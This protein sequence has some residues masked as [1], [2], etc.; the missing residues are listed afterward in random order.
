MKASLSMPKGLSE[1][2]ENLAAMGADVDNAAA[3]ALQAGA[4]T[5]LDEMLPNIHVGETGD[6][7]ATFRVGK[8]KREGNVT[9]IL[10]GQPIDKNLTPKRQAIVANVFEYGSSKM[11]A[12]PIVRP[13]MTG[14]KN[15]LTK[16]MQKKLEEKGYL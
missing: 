11:A 15:K 12:D 6:L 16:V 3:E 4:E 8:V 14:K 13:V 9:S 7:L 5:A 1:L 10:V 2:M